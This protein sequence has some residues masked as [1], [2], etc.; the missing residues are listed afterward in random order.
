VPA[1]FVLPLMMLAQPGV[2]MELALL[3]IK[4][5][6]CKTQFAFLHQSLDQLI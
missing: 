3:V 1:V 5:I 4:D 6:I 2:L